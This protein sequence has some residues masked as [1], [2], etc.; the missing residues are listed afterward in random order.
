MAVNLSLL[1]LLLLHVPLSLS[2]SA[3]HTN[4]LPFQHMRKPIFAPL[5]IDK[6]GSITD[7]LSRPA[8]EPGKA[9]VY[10]LTL[11]TSSELYSFNYQ[12]DSETGTRIADTEASGFSATVSSTL[13][14]LTQADSPEPNTLIFLAYVTVPDCIVQAG[15]PI[16]ESGLRIIRNTFGTDQ[17]CV[18][19]SESVD[20]QTRHAP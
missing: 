2:L 7:T 19:K 9:Y 20:N 18:K 3:S 13:T 10:N 15:N 14:I 16:G 1:L 17:D 12:Q 6:H 8:F 4:P 11:N 5:P